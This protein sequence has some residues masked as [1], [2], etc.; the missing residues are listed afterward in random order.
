GKPQKIER[1]YLVTGNTMR[2]VSAQSPSAPSTDAP[3][4]AGD[5]PAAP[6]R[7]FVLLFDLEHLQ[8]GAFKRLKDAAIGFLTREFRTGDVGGV[9]LGSTMAGNQLT[10][11]R[12]R[13]LA[14]V[15]DAKPSTAK[16]S[17]RL[18]LLEWPRLNGEPEAVRIALFNDRQVLAQAV[19]RACQDDPSACKADP[20]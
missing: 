15:R 8:E 4:Q 2:A 12:E 3:V 19:R 16:T 6:P 7:V 1:I 17:R 14:A 5:A 9:V 13:L 20:E 10:S 11:D 18:E